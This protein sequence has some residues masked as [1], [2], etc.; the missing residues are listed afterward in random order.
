MEAVLFVYA[1]IA[2]TIVNGLVA[3]RKGYE[4]WVAVVV[5]FF[6]G[7]FWVYIYLLAAPLKMPR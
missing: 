4:V 7:P 3:D 1:W 5:S 2:W 6:F